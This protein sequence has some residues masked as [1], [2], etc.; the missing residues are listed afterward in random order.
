MKFLDHMRNDVPDPEAAGF[1]SAIE[2]QLG[3]MVWGIRTAFDTD[4]FEYLKGFRDYLHHSLY[5]LGFW[6]AAL[7]VGELS[8]LAA[9]RVRDYTE[10]AWSA[11]YPLARIHYQRGNLRDAERWC[12]TAIGIFEGNQ[13]P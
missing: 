12:V 8:F 11:L 3:N 2:P 9:S 6:N 7:E 13:N 5:A 10:M 1:T 4:L